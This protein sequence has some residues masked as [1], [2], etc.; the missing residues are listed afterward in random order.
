MPENK[1]IR[2]KT[3]FVS[4]DPNRD[5]KENIKK[6]LSFFDDSII[7]VSGRTNDDPMLKNMMKKFKIYATRIDIEE[8]DENQ[9]GHEPV[10][11]EGKAANMNSKEQNQNEKP[12]EEKAYTIDHTIVTYLMN[13]QNQ[14]LTHIGANMGANDTALHIVT[15][16]LQDQ[17]ERL[18][19]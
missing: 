15:K 10:S 13:D 7:P 2:L 6:F 5:K 19:K 14:F 3:I 12:A 8:E 1:Y 4:V 18:L 11:K 17:R 16:I 9:A